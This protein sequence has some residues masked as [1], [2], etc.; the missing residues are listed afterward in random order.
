MSDGLVSAAMLARHLDALPVRERDVLEMRLG[1]VT[2]E[3]MTLAAIG[4]RLGVSRERV[5]QIEQRAMTLVRLRAESGAPPASPNGDRRLSLAA[6]GLGDFEPPRPGRMRCLGCG[7]EVAIG[8]T[9]PPLHRLDCLW[10]ARRRATGG[11]IVIDNL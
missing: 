4:F 9:P 6:L 11:R 1:L 10:C 3:P 7:R 8:A 5:R 2:G